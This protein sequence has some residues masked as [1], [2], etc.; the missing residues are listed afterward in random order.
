[1][2]EVVEGSPCPRCRR[3]L[4]AIV[5]RDEAKMRLRCIGCGERVEVGRAA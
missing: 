3:R 4:W 2:S 1:M 5:A